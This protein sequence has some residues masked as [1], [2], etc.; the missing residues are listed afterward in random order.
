MSL[1]QRLLSLLNEELARYQVLTHDEVFTA[2][3][4]AASAHVPGREVAKVVVVRDAGGYYL[5]AVIPATRRLDFAALA[6]ATGRG[7]LELAAEKEV[8][9]LFADCDAGAMPPFGNLYDLPLYLDACFPRAPEIFFQGG[10]H[11]E[12]VRMAYADY[13][14][15]ARPMVGQLCFHD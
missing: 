12:V 3:E 2:Q 5:M 14:R 13:E 10:N 1:S 4:V 6:R 9:Q 8:R 7:K 15:L 11:R